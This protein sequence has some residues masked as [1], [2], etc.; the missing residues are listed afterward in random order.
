MEIGASVPTL[1]G[2]LMIV[3]FMLGLV[4]MTYWKI[5]K[6]G[7]FKPF[8]GGVLVYAVFGLCVKGILDMTVLSVLPLG[9]WSYTAYQVV[10]V[11]AAETL[12]RYMGFQLLHKDRTDPRDGVSFGL[13]FGTLEAILT[14][15]LTSLMYRSYAVA[16][17]DGSAS[18]LLDVLSGADRAELS[19]ALAEVAA[20]TEADC[21]WA[22][23][24]RAVRL[25]MHT[26][27]AVTAMASFRLGQKR[28]LWIGAA[29][30]AVAILPISLYQSGVNLPQ[31]VGEAVLM[32]GTAAITVLAVRT[33][34][35]MDTEAV[36]HL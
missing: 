17:K 8:F 29:A 12:G 30:E 32:L 13:G 20:L 25:T 9:M 33:F 34:R 3:S 6:H 21:I 7:E 14:V 4:T 19:D 36:H 23:A 28:L 15:G 11:V 35:E 26:A 5:A 31:W 1:L 24:E 22:I 18:E 10:S 27:L 2:A 16:I